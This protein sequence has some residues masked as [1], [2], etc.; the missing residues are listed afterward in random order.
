LAGARHGATATRLGAVSRPHGVTPSLNLAIDRAWAK[1]ARTDVGLVDGA[2][3][4][5]VLFWDNNVAVADL[6]SGTARFRAQQVIGSANGSSAV[7][8]A[9]TPR[10]PRGEDTIDW[11]RARVARLGVAERGASLS[12]FVSTSSDGAMFG[13]EA[14]RA[15]L[16][17]SGPGRSAEV[18]IRN[19]AIRRAWHLSAVTGLHGVAAGCATVHARNVITGAGLLGTATSLRA[20]EPWLPGIHYAIDRAGDVRAIDL[21]FTGSAGFSAE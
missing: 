8:V 10:A 5:A 21:L 7:H 16:R 2:L 13:A 1:I 4:A 6:L 11:A 20:C 15:T 19:H 12:T 14:T 17:A 18:P 3:D 9:E